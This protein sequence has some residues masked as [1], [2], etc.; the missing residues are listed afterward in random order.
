VSENAHW[1]NRVIERSVR[2]AAASPRDRRNYN[3]IAERALRPTTRIVQSAAAL[4]QES[5]G[6]PFTVHEVLARAN[7]S[8]QTFYRHFGSRDALLLAVIEESVTRSAAR[9]RAQ[10]FSLDDPVSRVEYVVKAPFARDPRGLAVTITREHLRLLDSHAP[11]VEAADGAYRRLLADT[12]RAAQEAGRF[13]GL[14]ADEEA[15]LITTLVLSR[16]HQMVF[17]A[18]GR[19]LTS[20][21]A[22]IWAFSLA[23]LTRAAWPRSP[24]PAW[25]HSTVPNG[26][27]PTTRR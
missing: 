21:A 19:S 22:H 16:Y 9:F 25:H 8:L 1:K 26:P 11:E 27:T 2:R 18:A 7:V 12:L 17:G 6:A 4:A 3:L 20:E 10:A 24:E 13:L 15:D 5:S 14:G 23:A